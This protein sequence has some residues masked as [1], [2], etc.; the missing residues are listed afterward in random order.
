[1]N[2]P[3]MPSGY[4][5]GEFSPDRNR[6]WKPLEDRNAPPSETRQN[7]EDRYAPPERRPTIDGRRRL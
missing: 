3:R 1:M 7:L 4:Q 5:T 6:E 2:E